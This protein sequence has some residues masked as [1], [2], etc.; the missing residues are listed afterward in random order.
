MLG[1]YDVGYGKVYDDALEKA[2][3]QF[4]ID[5]DHG[6]KDGKV[7]R[8][9]RKLLVEKLPEANHTGIFRRMRTP[10]MEDIENKI[11]DSANL[12]HLPLAV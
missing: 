4:Q 1:Y 7:G 2:V 8:D 12:A 6:S 10:E 11:T 9:T 5:N 3:Q